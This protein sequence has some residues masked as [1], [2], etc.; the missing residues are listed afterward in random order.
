MARVLGSDAAGWIVSAGLGLYVFFG[1][2]FFK[3]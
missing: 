2:G 1:K 3:R